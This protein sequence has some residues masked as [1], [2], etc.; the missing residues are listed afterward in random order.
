MA[1]KKPEFRLLLITD[2]KKC[3]DLKQVILS[4]CKAG[5]KAVQLREKSANGGLSSVELLSLSKELRRIT[6]ANSSN[7]IINDRLDICLL[8]KADGVH[9]PEKGFLPSQIKKYNSKLLAGKSV[10]SVEN[11]IKAERNGYDYILAGPVFRTA[12]KVKYGKP[13]GLKVLNEIC[14]AVNIPVYAVGGIN[15]ERAKKCISQ[16]AYGVAVIS[17]IMSAKS[18]KQKVKEFEKALGGL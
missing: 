15:P 5:V 17:E 12:S 7:L 11:A 2:R 13:L 1:G 3:K 4:A 6:K 14:N 16:G 9:S 8:V 18:V 10:H